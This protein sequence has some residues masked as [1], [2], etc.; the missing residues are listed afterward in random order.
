M[1]EVCDKYL[2]EDGYIFF[3]IGREEGLDALPGI[4]YEDVETFE[5]LVA[6]VDDIVEYKQEDYPELKMVVW[7]T[8][9]ELT[10]LAYEYTLDEWNRENPTKRAKSIK[11]THGGLLLNMSPRILED[12]TIY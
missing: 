9:D 7:D 12:I 8:L 5:D 3:N 2:G 4:I 10:R 11:A 1:Y 6:M